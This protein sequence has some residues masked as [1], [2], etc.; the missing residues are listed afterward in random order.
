ME[1]RQIE[2][3]DTLALRSLVLRNNAPEDQCIF[4]GDNDEQTFHL[5]AYVDERLVSVAS[6]YLC[7]H[8]NIEDEYQ[9]RLRG[10]ATHPDFRGQGLSSALLNAGFPQIKN[11]HIKK[12]WCNARSSA[13]GFYEKI[14]F[15]KISDEFEIAGIGPHFTM[16]IDL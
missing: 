1:V 6:F 16:V 13:V 10:M 14:G 5:G 11:N 15:R 8:A 3:K 12:V 9:Y 2:A 7:N 4:E